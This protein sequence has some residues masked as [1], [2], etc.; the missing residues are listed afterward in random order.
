MAI[1]IDQ[2]A[3]KHLVDT[4]APGE[5]GK[6]AFRVLFYII[7]TMD[8]DNK[9]KIDQQKLANRLGVSGQTLY[10]ATKALCDFGFIAKAPT[11]TRSRTFIV[12]PALALADQT[13]NYEAIMESFSEAQNIGSPTP[14]PEA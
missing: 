5:V 11:N 3:L 9:V 10:M 7:S 2:D 13:S 4:T 8:F 14:S 1:Q 12:S 6:H